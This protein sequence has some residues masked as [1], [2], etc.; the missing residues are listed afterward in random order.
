M[1]TKRAKGGTRCTICDLSLK[2]SLGSAN[3]LEEATVLG[4][5]IHPSS[6]SLIALS[7]HTKTRP[8]TQMRALPSSH[9]NGVCDAHELVGS[10]VSG[11]TRW[12]W[13]PPAAGRAQHEAMHIVCPSEMTAS[14]RCDAKMRSRGAW[15]VHIVPH[16]AADSADRFALIHRQHPQQTVCRARGLN[17]SA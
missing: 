3:V 17:L 10:R 11:L 8:P 5:E 15:Q 2:Y 9:A 4:E 7:W 14:G 6:P 13:S 16:T 12:L 1:R